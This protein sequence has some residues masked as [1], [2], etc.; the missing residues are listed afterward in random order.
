MPRRSHRH[1]SAE[2]RELVERQRQS[3]L[4][5]AAFCREHDLVYQ[6]FVGWRRRVE[7]GSRPDAIA[8]PR[9][10]ASSSAAVPEFIELGVAHGAHAD[11]D[12]PN[13]AHTA[14]WLVELDLGDGLTLRLRRAA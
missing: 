13:T 5:A 7:A 3:G 12:A 2:R 8:A 6:T 10:S 14:E 9:S 11:A 1:T 4:S